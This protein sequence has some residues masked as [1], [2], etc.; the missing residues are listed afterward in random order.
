MT[1]LFY[2]KVK[3]CAGH[4]GNARLLMKVGDLLELDDYGVGVITEIWSDAFGRNHAS[5]WL[6]AEKRYLFFHDLERC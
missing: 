1:S 3:K 2:A 4:H 6:V 5:I